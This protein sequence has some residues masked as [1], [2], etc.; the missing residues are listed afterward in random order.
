MTVMKG[1]GHRGMGLGLTVWTRTV[2]AK[3]KNQTA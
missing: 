1:R 3:D 2:G